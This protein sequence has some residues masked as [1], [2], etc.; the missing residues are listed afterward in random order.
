MYMISP[1]FIRD[2]LTK[3]FSDIGR[4]SANDR[5]FIMESP[6]IKND[7][8]KHC[9][10]N[11]DSG[12]WQCFKTGRDGNFV[13]LYSHLQ[14]IP[15]FRAQKELIIKNFAYLGKPVPLGVMPKENKLELDTSKL[16]PLNIASGFSDDP[17]VL[18]AWSILYERKLFTEVNETKAEYF[19]CKEGK[20]ANRII[21][22]F[23]RDGIVFYFQARALGDQKPKYLNPSTEIAPKSSDILYPYRDDM[24]PLVVCE[25]P[26]DAISFQLQGIN[27]TATMKN[28]VSPRQAEMLSTFD[29][30]IILA[31]D[32]DSAGE[33]GFEAFDK[34]RKERLM[35]EFFVCKPPSGYK[36]WNEAHQN[37]VDLTNHLE[38]NIKLY[39]FQYRMHNQI[40]L[41]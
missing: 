32:N 26:L 24:D 9:S 22:P 16:I 35:D 10:V 34:L 33:R 20:F 6:F 7:Y 12:L 15:Y 27:A 1:Q 28:I 2:F 23:T 40:N 41:V 21:I 19:L 29:G 25:G 11:V 38:D 37:G 39:D 17:E 36:D 8:K 5:E 18:N 3:N 14:G 31:F 13:S 4:L 30:D